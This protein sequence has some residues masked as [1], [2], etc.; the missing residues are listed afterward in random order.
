METGDVYNACVE[1]KREIEK[2]IQVAYNKLVAEDVQLNVNVTTIQ[3]T[4]G[5]KISVCFET[6]VEAIIK[7]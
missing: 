4:I 6:N 5:G 7:P 2:S 1:L 3:T